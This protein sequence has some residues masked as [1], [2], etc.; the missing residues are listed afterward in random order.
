MQREFTVR[1]RDAERFQQRGLN[2]DG[3]RSAPASI[4]SR[5]GSTKSLGSVD[6]SLTSWAQRAVI[7]VPT[8][9]PEYG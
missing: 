5:E 2:H 1:E 9:G 4:F 6:R 7:Y 8:V 3:D